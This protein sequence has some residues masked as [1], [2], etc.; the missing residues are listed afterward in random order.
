MLIC[1]TEGNF[2]AK[3]FGFRKSYQNFDAHFPKHFDVFLTDP[4]E[5]VPDEEVISCTT[6][7]AVFTFVRRRHHCRNCGKVCFILC[8]SAII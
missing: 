8:K 7:R 4:P 6:C 2:K 1:F 5:W 3:N